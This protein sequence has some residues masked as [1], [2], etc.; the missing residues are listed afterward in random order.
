MCYYRYEFVFKLATGRLDIC[1][2]MYICCIM[3]HVSCN[4]ENRIVDDDKYYFL[5]WVQVLG[6]G[7]T[8]ECQ[9]CSSICSLRGNEILWNEKTE[10][11]LPSSSL[12]IFASRSRLRLCNF[13]YSSFITLQHY[14]FLSH[15]RSWILWRPCCLI[16]KNVVLRPWPCYIP[17]WFVPA[18]LVPVPRVGKGYPKDHHRCRNLAV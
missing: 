7:L 2:Y 4:S 13:W 5:V 9:I 14:C 16:R 12:F 1:L 17:L 6:L 10:N 11:I 3:Y 18:R 8:W 15:R